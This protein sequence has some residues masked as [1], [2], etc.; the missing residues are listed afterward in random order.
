[1]KS[2][3][4]FR[5]PKASHEVELLVVV[6]S[7]CCYC[8]CC[9]VCVLFVVCVVVFDVFVCGVAFGLFLTV[10]VDFWRPQIPQ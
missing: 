10:E 3:F 9:C 5:G 4:D 6:G 1:M 8:C 2:S 7:W